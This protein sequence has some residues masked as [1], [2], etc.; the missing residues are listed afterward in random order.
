M[1]RKLLLFF[2]ML[3]VSI[4]AWATITIT[5]DPNPY[6]Q[7]WIGNEQI[8]NFKVFT[9]SG[10]DNPGDVAKLLN[11]DTSLSVNWNGKSL[12]DLTGAIIIHLGAGANTDLLNE[13]DLQAL[14][15]LTSTK[16]LD[17]DGSKLADG[18][19]INKIEIGSAVE[20][21]VLPDGLSKDQVNGVATILSASENFGSCISKN[22]V[23]TVSPV[24]NYYYTEGNNSGQKVVESNT[25]VLDKENLTA[26]VK[27]DVQV[28]LTLQEG[29]PKYK[30]TNTWNNNKEVYVADTDIEQYDAWGQTKYRIKPNPLEVAVKKHLYDSNNN[31]RTNDA[32]KDD[33][34]YYV[35]TQKSDAKI[36][37]YQQEGKD[38]WYNDPECT[39]RNWNAN[40]VQQD[41][42]GNYYY[43]GWA[44][45]KEYLTE[46]Y[47]YYSPKTYQDVAYTGTTPTENPDG[48]LTGTIENT[49]EY[50]DVTSEYLYTY[51]LDDQIKEYP[52]NSEDTDLKLNTTHDVKYTVEARVEE[53]TTSEDN[54]IAYV[55]KAGSLYKSTHVAPVS[56]NLS[57]VVI[58]GNVNNGDIAV[59]QNATDPNGSKNDS[60]KFTNTAVAAFYMNNKSCSIKSFDIGDSNIEDYKYLRVLDAFGESL[61]S[62]VFPKT[63]TR[64]PNYCCFS[65]KNAVKNLANVVFPTEASS[66]TIGDY[67]FHGIAI[68][69]LLLPSSVTHVG[70]NAFAVCPNLY[71]VEM[72][73]LKADCTF[74]NNVFEQ[75]PAL[76]HVTL[77]EKVKN[78]GDY[79]FNQCG[80]LESIRIPSTCTTI[81]SSA[82][83]FCFSIHQITI[84]EGV[85]LIKLNA[86]EGAGLTDIYL[87]ATSI[88]TLPKIYAMSPSGAGPSTFTSQRTTGNNT[89]PTQHRDKLPNAD[90]DEVMTWYQEEQSGAEGLGT[91]NCL[92]ALHYPESL[93]P[94]FEAIDVTDFYEPDELATIPLQ[95]LQSGIQH[96]YTPDDYLDM[97][98]A[99]NK[100][101]LQYIVNNQMDPAFGSGAAADFGL[102]E[103]EKPI[104]YQYLPQ[105][106]AVDPR[107]N[108][109]GTRIFGPDKDGLCYPNQ[110]SYL[111]RMAAG[112]T[113]TQAGGVGGQEVASAWGWRQFPLAASIESIGEIPF[114][115]EYDD[116]WYTMCFPW[117][118]ED[119]QL[120]SAFNQ[121]LEIV[122]FKGAE[123]FQDPKDEYNY[124]LVFHFD[125]VAKTY[126]MDDEDVEY[127][128]EK[129]GTRT[130]AAG[131]QLYIYTSKKDGTEV[132]APNPLPDKNTTDVTAKE[133]YGKYLSIKNIMVLPGHPYMIHPSIGAAPGN[134]ATVYINGVKKIEVGEGKKF[135]TLADV[136]ESQK[137]ERTVTSK[138]AGSTAEAEV[139]TNPVTGAGGKYTFIGNIN[140]AKETDDPLH[141]GAQNM[142]TDKG[143]VY[144]LGVKD[145]TYYPQFFKKPKGKGQGKWSQYSAIIVP[146]DDAIANVEGLD[147]MAAGSGTTAPAKGYDVVF[148]EWEIVD[149]ATVV[150]AIENAQAEAEETGKPAQ[151]THMN[152]VYNIKG[153]V[154]RADSSSVEGLPKGLYIVN[155]KKYMVK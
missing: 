35:I 104:L 63:V 145:G 78:I 128:R 22:T 32:Q 16:Y 59:N 99:Q 41:D 89:V 106:Y 132:K 138:E 112:A 147:G 130:D 91:G 153:Q 25:V 18:A 75:C 7:T 149:E 137:V 52:T 46:R 49:T 129:D 38:G 114:E 37:V 154:V 125:E 40:N 115:K 144:F 55:N 27:E 9:I 50:F 79:M 148:G 101:T 48:S 88:A 81:G 26:T 141:P 119:N 131:H 87:M 73:G 4:G 118:M 12:S 19:S 39:D 54:V 155:G 34:G 110:T 47:T 2:A 126:Y 30:Y 123:V 77:S 43:I 94:F 76:Q 56:Y 58:S 60:D 15:L 140:D 83:Q 93:K 17:M 85:E 143:P 96:Y 136:A 92:T 57:S 51:E 68:N 72:E 74:G 69:S 86:F 20:G 120:F 108:N 98:D 10:W 103:D 29:Y 127:T 13:D 90:Y 28:D 105:S 53:E 36:I 142:P 45:V 146:D 139:W 3:C 152:V 109:S 24:T 117:K 84:P 97:V 121:K 95:T 111:L 62:V 33:D 8:S 113:S 5:P 1:K 14:N 21:V 67:A 102:D 135:A 122:E 80:L 100:A 133:Q 44:N 23:F 31:D 71:D 65:S 6:N 64:I 70:D 124:N 107:Q 151:I 66:F 134:P 150:T 42:S 82:F 116:T 61:E 11:G